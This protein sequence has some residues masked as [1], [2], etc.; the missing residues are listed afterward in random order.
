M[1]DP[2]SVAVNPRP[3][4][5]RNRDSLRATAWES[6]SRARALSVAG[7]QAQSLCLPLSLFEYP[8]T[9]GSLMFLVLALS[10][11][12]SEAGRR[13]LRSRWRTA[14]P[15]TLTWGA[16]A[17]AVSVAPFAFYWLRARPLPVS[18]ADVSLFS[19]NLGRPLHSQSAHDSVVW[20]ALA[21][22]VW[23]PAC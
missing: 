13:E 2:V 12:I 16:V 8:R 5:R 11:L 18:P 20:S 15:G 19:A 14:C 10:L 23:R 6:L 3:A 7:N 22:A 21:S 1:A 17:F 4:V 9:I